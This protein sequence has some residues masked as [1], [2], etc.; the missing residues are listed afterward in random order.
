M[1][2]FCPERVCDTNYRSVMMKGLVFTEFFE[3]VEQVFDEDMVD[4]LIEKTN[5]V[6]KGAYTTMGSYSYDELEAMFIELHKQSDVE[7]S[8]LLLAF[9]KHLAAQ[10]AHKYEHFFKDAGDTLALLK[11]VDSHIHIEVKKLYPDAELP[12]L[13]YAEHNNKKFQLVYRSVRPLA[14]LAHGMIIQTSH[15]FQ[16]KFDISKRQWTEG[17]DNVCEFELTRIEG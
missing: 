5:P 8:S 9:G 17:T 4:T 13:S 15:Y 1:S 14:D 3:M 7:V 10:F 12:Q 16:E 2:A 11:K 6:S